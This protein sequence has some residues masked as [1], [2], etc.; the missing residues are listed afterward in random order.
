MNRM[1]LGSSFQI[2]F[3]TTVTPPVVL[4]T[5]LINY[6]GVDWDV[7]EGCVV[8]PQGLVSITGTYVLKTE[9][10]QNVQLSITIGPFYT[11]LSQLSP[12]KFTLKAFAS[13]PSDGPFDYWVD[14]IPEGLIPL[15]ECD[16]PCRTCALPSRT[17][18]LS[19][20]TNVISEALKYLESAK[21]LSAC[22]DGKFGDE[23]NDKIC[24]FCPNDCLTCSDVQTCTR[25][26]TNYPLTELYK[27]WCVSSCPPGLCPINFKC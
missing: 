14:E 20:Q 21:C 2:T 22:P 5:C 3:P 19:C 8:D 25:C 12:G 10:A 7:S 27:G 23:F 26:K 15:F 16:H 17:K 6:Q 1:P 11:P 24:T 18:C 4:S 9:V 13:Y